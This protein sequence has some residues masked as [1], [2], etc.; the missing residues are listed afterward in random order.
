VQH[1][2]PA[3]YAWG[4]VT[5][6]F[7][8]LPMLIVVPLSFSTD[9]LLRWPP[10]G[11]TLQWYD[12]F[13][14]DPLWTDAIW[15]SLEVAGATVVLATL[16][17]T[18]LALGLDRARFRGRAIVNAVA[19]SPIVIP[20]IILAIG[21]FFI[22]TTLRLTGTVRGLILAHTV[23]ATPLV[24]VSV[25]ASLRGLD[26]NLE[27]AAQNLGANPLRVFLRITLPLIAPGMFAGALFAF[28]ISWDE[29]VVALF[30]TGPLVK[31]LPVVM[32]SQV[33]TFVDPTVA[34]AATVML[35]VTTLVLVIALVVRQRAE[36]RKLA[37]LVSLEVRF[38][39][40]E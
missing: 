16:L 20:A 26:S 34:A 33:T 28:I 30:V 32:W 17:G 22:F 24:L 3:L 23:L 38:E 4:A 31:T 21:I 35:A 18:S 19:I 27:R 8:V 1:W 39:G 36:R 7:L 12:T 40:M 15:T 10:K 2:R 11:F 5:G 9:P 14:T 6:L 13:L 25:L 37:D 29:I